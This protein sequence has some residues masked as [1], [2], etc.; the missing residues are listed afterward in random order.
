MFMRDIVPCHDRYAGALTRKAEP[1][2]LIF[3]SLAF[4]TAHLGFLARD[5]CRAARAAV[6]IG[7]TRCQS[8]Q[9]RANICHTA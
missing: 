2:S 3:A 5:G 6:V 4:F 9:F 1:R 8:V 7:F